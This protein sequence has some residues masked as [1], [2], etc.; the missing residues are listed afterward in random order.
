MGDYRAVRDMF[1][2]SH[3]DF[4]EENILFLVCCYDVIMRNPASYKAYGI[5]AIFVRA[6]SPV[7]INIAGPVRANVAAILD[8][9]APAD[10]NFIVNSRSDLEGLAN[11]PAAD[12]PNMW[13]SIRAFDLCWRSMHSASGMK[14]RSH[15]AKIQ[16]PMH[17]MGR[18]MLTGRPRK[19]FGTQMVQHLMTYWTQQELVNM[20]VH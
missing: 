3:S 1:H 4:T 17:A 9:H 16:N 13:P 6:G 7:E 19:A 18:T 11:S 5:G 8:G 10:S 12:D 15:A 20:G 14:Y 2:K